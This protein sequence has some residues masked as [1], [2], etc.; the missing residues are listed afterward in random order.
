MSE[1][2][3]EYVYG[4]QIVFFQIVSLLFAL[5]ATTYIQPLL[6]LIL[7][8]LSMVPLLVPQLL[9]KKLETVNRDAAGSKSRYL[10]VLNELLEDFRH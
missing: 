1:V 4:V 7:I 6:T 9:K 8:I 5:I 2:E 3:S 10:N